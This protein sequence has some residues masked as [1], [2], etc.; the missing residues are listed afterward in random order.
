MHSVGDVVGRESRLPTRPRYILAL[1][2]SRGAVRCGSRHSD[3]RHAGAAGKRA[4]MPRQAGKLHIYSYSRGVNHRASISSE[5]W[6]ASAGR[7]QT[8]MPVW[9]QDSPAP[10]SPLP[11]EVTRNA[12]QA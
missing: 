8:P 9:R 12:T 10:R 4:D 7:G 6:D 3:R 5:R 2:V 1:H 11:L